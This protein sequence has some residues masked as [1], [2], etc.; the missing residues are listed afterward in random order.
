MEKAKVCV[1]RERASSGSKKGA[2]IR[3]LR[4]R[5]KKAVVLAEDETTLRLFPPLRQS[6]SVRGSQACV[7][8]TGR[9]DRRVLFGSLNL[10]TGTRIVTLEKTTGQAGFQSHLRKIRRAFG[11]R[12]V[13]LLLDRG[14]SHMAKKSLALARELNITLIWLPKQWSEYNAMDQL[15]KELKTKVAANRQYE[16]ADK[17]AERAR[18]WVLNLSNRDA[19]QKAG[20]RSTGWWLRNI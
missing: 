5:E 1:Q 16:S 4:K 7:F 12:P 6:W 14:P 20:V 18:Q 2:I 8:I 11:R 9:N 19:L 3:R 10:Q 13:Y 15:W 17:L